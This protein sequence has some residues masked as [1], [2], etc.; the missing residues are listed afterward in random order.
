MTYTQQSNL[1]NK[2]IVYTS[3]LIFN[4]AIANLKMQ[5]LT[6]TIDCDKVFVEIVEL[7]FLEKQIKTILFLC[8]Q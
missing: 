5:Q 4:V 3:K 6:A 8:V 1:Y 7:S 2:F